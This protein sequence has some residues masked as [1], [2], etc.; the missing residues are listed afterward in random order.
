ML[1]PSVQFG[2]F[3]PIVLALSWA[4]M[5]RP[6][7]WKP[8]ILVASY[9][10]YAAASPV[11]C[12][13]LGGVTLWN[14]GAAKLIHRSESDRSRA[15]LCAAAVA[16]D[17]LALGIFKYY[18]FFVQAFARVLH[19]IGLGMPLPLIT[20]ALPVGIS[21]FTFQAISYTVDVKRGLIEPPRLLD[22]GIYLSF[23][24]HLVAGP[25]VRAREF[26]PQLARP[27]DPEH[28]AV[29]AGLMLIGMGLVKKVVIADYLGRTVVDPVF[30]VPQAFHGPDVLLAAYAYTAQ[31]YCDFSGYT[32]I[33]IG[34]ALLL[35]FVFPQNFN[36]PYRATGF[37][38]YWRRWHM[39]LS[40]FL[41]DF[42]YIPLGGNRRGRLMTYRNLMI[43][44]VLGG[45]WHGAAW[46]FVIWG[47]L[48]GV[49]LVT[50]HA[51]KGRFKWPGWL[52]WF[53]TFHLIVLGFIVFRSQGIGTAW[54]LFKRLGSI[55]SP[56][57]LTVPVALAIAVAIVPQ[58]LP[59]SPVQRLQ[60]W[61]GTLRPEL[62]AAA[63]GVLILFVAATVPSQGVPPFI[64]FRF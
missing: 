4:L 12:L 56:T 44:M 42:L 8:F 29:S 40:R 3:F 34:L 58:L 11:F 45:L 16:G 37:Q 24:P 54:T 60:V 21:F 35:G 27:R 31:I 36:S 51:L 1:F 26:L 55:A 2:I 62:L 5:S 57:L 20:I 61:I 18:S 43:T 10:F 28:V 47:A 59:P 30:G 17:L 22:T 38:D 63:L 64:Y 39:T 52:R 14:H 25:I 41:R 7:L 33:A 46:T 23:F 15:R 49:G 48:H 50:E 19:S 6:A 32:D 53:V 13:L 9:V